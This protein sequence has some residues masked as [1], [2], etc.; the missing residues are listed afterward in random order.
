M[1][2]GKVSLLEVV[3]LT[4]NFGGLRA[5]DQL[6]FHINEGEILGLIG[7]NGAGKTTV[8]NLISGV[9]SPSSGTIKFKGQVISG[10]KPHNI[11]QMGLVRTFQQTSLFRG[12]TVLENMAVGG[13]SK[14]GVKIL[15]TILNSKSLKAK[16]EQFRA[17]NLKILVMLGLDKFKDEMPPNLPYGYQRTLGV[18]LALASNPKM[19]LLDEPVTGMNPEETAHMMRIV[20]GIRDEGVTV[21]LVEHDMKMVMGIC[22]RIVAISFGKKLTEGSPEEVR[23]DDRVIKAYLGGGSFD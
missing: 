5:V 15:G 4:K 23:N 7:P 6:T 17:Q 11:A 19:L 3:E 12:M 18:A 16:V 1:R 14:S 10:S 20:K 22:E 9:Y 2:D 13:H 8:F 21:L